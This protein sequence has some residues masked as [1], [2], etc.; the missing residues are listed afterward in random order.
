MSN[1]PQTPSSPA[2]PPE[3]SDPQIDFKIGEEYGTARKSLPP[4]GIVAIG[5]L[6]V[7]AIA[8]IYSLTHR[9]HPLSTGSI[10]EI[11]AAP[12]PG[13][14]IL[15]VAV[16]VTLQGDEQKAR[17]IKSIQVSTDMNGQTQ[18]DDAA[19]AVDAQRYI[20]AFPDLKQHALQPLAPEARLSPGEKKSG[21]IV[22]SFPVTAEAFAA[23]KSLTVTIIPYGEVPVV[24]TK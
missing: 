2:P 5:V 6:A 24:L 15:M 23:R 10:D 18:S 7:V 19:P 16:N 9:A 11:T 17:W 20:D 12:V 21:T 8:A 22:V 4:V 14:A 1:P 13:Q 3:S